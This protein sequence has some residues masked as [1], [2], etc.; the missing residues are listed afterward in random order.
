MANSYFIEPTRYTEWETSKKQWRCIFN[1]PKQA[2]PRLSLILDMPIILVR[3]HS[4]TIHLPPCGSNALPSRILPRLNTTLPTATGT[5]VAC[6]ATTTKHI[7]CCLSRLSTT[8]SVRNS[9]LPTAMQEV[10][11]WKKTRTNT[12]SGKTRP[13][14]KIRN[15]HPS[16]RKRRLRV[17][18]TFKWTCL[19]KSLKNNLRILH[20]HNRNKM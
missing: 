19:A 2:T 7:T 18:L 17:I 4:A 16:N 6:H 5:V 9:P 11:L 12:T 13:K 8:T 3:E 10:C 20:R 1:L 15:K 14:A